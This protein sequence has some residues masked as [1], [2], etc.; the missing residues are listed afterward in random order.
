MGTP[1]PTA[2]LPYAVDLLVDLCAV[3]V[4]FLTSTGHRE[5]NASRMP[6]S[7]T[8]NLAQ[9]FVGLAWQF[10]GVPARSDTWQKESGSK[11]V[12]NGPTH[13]I[14]PDVGGNIIRR[15]AAWIVQ[16]PQKWYQK[17]PCAGT[18]TMFFHHAMQ[19]H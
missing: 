14:K 15:K 18:C 9:T 12:A 3:M 19:I 13:H 6:G 11:L 16:Q 7:N 4:A 17:A 1:F 10:L 2:Y 5:T 8:G